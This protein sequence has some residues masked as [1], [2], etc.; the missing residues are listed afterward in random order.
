MKAYRLKHV[1]TGLYYQ[2]ESKGS[3][4]SLTGQ[5]YTTTNN[6]LGIKT[7]KGQSE[8]SFSVVVDGVRVKE[9]LIEK[10]YLKKEEVNR[11]RSYINI[12]RSEFEKEYLTIT[13]TKNGDS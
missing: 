8:R 10:K 4:L 7:D 1:P 13:I 2:R 12:S 5:I 11:Y 6:G 9:I 3:A